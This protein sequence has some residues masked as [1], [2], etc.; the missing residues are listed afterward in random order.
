MKSIDSLLDRFCLNHP[1][2]GIP[3]LMLIISAGNVIVLLLDVFSNYTFSYLLR[4]IPGAI[5]RGQ[6]WRLVTF[7][8]VPVNENLLWFVFS[9]LLYYSIGTSLERTWGTTKFTVYYLLGAVMNAV[10]G[11]IMGLLGFAW[12]ETANMYYLN[13]SLFLAYATL[14]PDA[15]FTIYFIIPV[16][17]KWLAWIDAAFLALAVVWNLFRLNIPMALMPVLAV[18]NYLLFFWSDITAM[19]GRTRNRARHQTSRQTVNFKQ[20]TRR[21]QQQK[22]YI[23]KCAV[24]GKTDTE[25]PDEEFRYCSKCNGYYCYCS[26]HLNNHVHIP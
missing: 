9:V 2:L 1:K 11:L 13:M 15:V 25:F 14:Y 3:N 17:A 21:A 5:F 10:V 8:F 22:G 23:H 18:L 19:A 16:K 4:F 26:E 24:C 20:A 7:L 12:L 6:V